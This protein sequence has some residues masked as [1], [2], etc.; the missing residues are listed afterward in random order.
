MAGVLARMDEVRLISCERTA[1]DQRRVLVG[2]ATTGDR[3]LR[4]IAPLIAAQ[5]ERIDAVYGQQVAGQPVCRALQD[6]MQ[7]E[8][9]PAPQVAL[10]PRAKPA[11]S[12]KK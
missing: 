12:R 7:A 4:Q 5:Y 8:Q 9:D 11:R 6:F 2:P 1:A 10:P 3:L